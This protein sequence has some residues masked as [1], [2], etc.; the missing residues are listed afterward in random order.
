METDRQT[1]TWGYGTEN[2]ELKH[3]RERA[4]EMQRKE[5]TQWAP[6][7]RRRNFIKEG[8]RSHTAVKRETEK[9]K[10]VMGHMA[11]R[12]ELKHRDRELESKQWRKKKLR[13]APGRRGKN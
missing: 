11:A 2:V 6:R 3:R 12:E 8:T 5:K 9:G 13:Q 10:I 7:Q 4:R 1:N